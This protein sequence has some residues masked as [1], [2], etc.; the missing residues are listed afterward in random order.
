MEIEVIEKRK[1]ALFN[2][3]EI[4]FKLVHPKEPTPKRDQ[5]RDKIAEL[6]NVKKEQIVVDELATTF[7]KGE[8]I[9]YAKVYTTKKE[10]QENERN[11]HLKRNHIFEEKKKGAPAEKK[12]E[13]PAEPAAE[14]E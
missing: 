3:E 13:A 9:G 8:T 10:A 2:R 11:Y 1:N 7:G 5:A 12:E 14:G 6:S 4:R